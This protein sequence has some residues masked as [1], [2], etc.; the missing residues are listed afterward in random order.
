MK[1]KGQVIIYQTE[2]GQFEVNVT[3]TDDT[4]WLSQ[5]QMAQ[6]FDVEVHTINYHIKEI[7]KSSELEENSVIRKIRITAADGKKYDT[8]FYNLDAIISVGYRVNSA[9]ATKF[10]IWATRTLK[11]YLLKGYAMNQKRLTETGV[12]ELE[13]ALEFIKQ[14]SSHRQLSNEE[15][16]GLLEVIAKY[17]KSWLLLKSYDEDDLPV[18]KGH[19]PKFMLA[20]DYA[21]DVI[22]K[23]KTSL[24]AKG[25]AFD[26]F[27]HER[28][29]GLEA[30]L[31]NLAQSFDGEDLYQ[32]LEKKAAHLLYFIIKDHPFIDGNKRVASL[33]FIHYLDKNNRL[34][35]ENGE[36][37]INDNALVALALLIAESEP[38]NK[39]LMISLVENLLNDGIKQ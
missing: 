22:V 17:A 10:R 35:K 19:T 26:I 6:L 12:K 24:I 7:F 23:L 11:E 30:I 36:P 33:L 4:V 1:N 28:E 21:K 39:E 13:S 8:N 34:Y 25:E 15:A 18:A 32:T 14:A 20:Y 31:G 38:K 3:L 37:I 16:Q 2:D 27:G 5:K 29:H 9:K